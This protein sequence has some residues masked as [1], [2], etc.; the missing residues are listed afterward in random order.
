MNEELLLETTSLVGHMKHLYDNEN[1]TF[2][3][4]KE[5]FKAAAN[6]E[7]IG[8]EKAD[9]INILISFSIREGKAKGLRSKSD[10]S[11]GGLNADELA[12]RFKDNEN[13]NI[14]NI[15]RNALLSFEKTVHALDHDKQLDLFGDNA[16]IF[17]NADI[18]DSSADTVINYDTRTIVIHQS[19]HI[20]LNNEKNKV[21]NTNLTDKVNELKDALKSSQ[22][23][24][25]DEQYGVQ[26]NAIRRLQALN[27]K[28]PLNS[29][30]SRIDSILASVNHLINNDNLKLGDDSTIF[31]FIIA[32]VYILIN[33]ILDKG[34]EKIGSVSPQAKMNIAKRILGVEGIS[35]NDITRKLT[36]EQK[37]FVTNNILNKD[38]IKNIYKISLNPIELI[39]TDFT[40]EMLKTLQSAFILDQREEINRIKKRVADAISQ[41]NKS[42]DHDAMEVLKNQLKKL[43]SADNVSSATEGFVFDYD[44]TTYKFTGNFAPVNQ[45]MNLFRKVSPSAGVLEEGVKNNLADLVL[46]PGAFRPPHAGHMDM[47]EKCSKLGKKVVVLVSPLPRALPGGVPV[48][49]NKTKEIF[50]KYIDAYK[51][52]NVSVMQSHLNS[53]VTSIMDFISNK[54]NNPEYLQK[55]KKIIVGFSDKDDDATKH[56][57]D[58]SKL[59]RQDL[60]V[61]V[62]PIKNYK[63]LNSTDMRDFIAQKDVNKLKNYLPNKLG[64][65][66]KQVA[67]DIISMFENKDITESVIYGTIFETIRKRGNKYCLLSLKTK[68]NLGCYS[69]RK[70][71]KHREKQVN[72]FKHLNKEE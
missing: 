52:K 15:F 12:M 48:T 14:K 68:K 66:K 57:I 43:K 35:I 49:F 10:L 40:S 42:G 33:S 20:E 22:D 17:Y 38:S 9:G 61:E 26:V 39:V 31:D 3:K 50:D 70:K 53:P 54:N 72:Y 7:L 63:K 44:G 32:R 29:A 18:L 37:V 71:A 19:G 45:I 24:I 1:L 47:I 30:I 67:H 6:G 62:V 28:K 16:N 25:K 4:M 21:I 23:R 60:D 27:D 59:D 56:N 2:A 41:I 69:S 36:P 5:I 11:S 34:R 13:P 58:V 65:N 51:L 8:T 46:V 64:R 55:E